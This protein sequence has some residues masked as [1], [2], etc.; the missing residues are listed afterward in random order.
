MKLR[1]A[2]SAITILILMTSCGSTKEV[3]IT[4]KKAL[5]IAKAFRMLS[6]SESAHKQAMSI[7]L[8]KIS[9]KKVDELKVISYTGAACV[10]LIFSDQNSLTAVLVRIKPYNKSSLTES[11][12]TM[13]SYL[14]VP[15]EV[16]GE[17]SDFLA[18]I[19]FE[20]NVYAEWPYFLLTHNSNSVW[21]QRSWTK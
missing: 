19:N 2:L 21:I 16:Y 1:H 20:L 5:R 15:L 10:K 8:R 4:P 14:G 3:E 13:Q 12:N 9:S 11:A 18:G 6:S 7:E 17:W